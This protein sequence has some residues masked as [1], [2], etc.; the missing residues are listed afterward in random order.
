[1]ILKTINYFLLQLKSFSLSSVMRELKN[2]K[3]L[4]K[5]GCDKK[6][7]DDKTILKWNVE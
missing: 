6:T 3:E 4:E 7:I 5:I 2:S 1:M